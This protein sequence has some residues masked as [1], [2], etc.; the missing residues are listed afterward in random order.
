M[1]QPPSLHAGHE[2][3]S[4][5]EGY[6][7]PDTLPGGK[8]LY[9]KVVVPLDGSAASESILPYIA[10]MAEKGLMKTLIFIRVAEGPNTLYFGNMFLAYSPKS[11]KSE[12]E[13]RAE[14]ES[15]LRIFA[16]KLRYEGVE[17]TWN[18][19]PYG[20]VADMIA[21]YVKEIK[22]DLIIMAT[23][24]RKGIYRWIWGSVAEDVKRA[25]SIPVLLI[26]VH[27]DDYECQNMAQ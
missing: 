3:A 17:I 25:V 12:P 8:K 10:E 19:L 21:R 24:G 26:K 2:T 18:A 20:G 4:S 6:W 27:Q 15:Y 23:H 16:C 9:N 14:A 13:R 5:W 7:I 1:A 11:V 22:A